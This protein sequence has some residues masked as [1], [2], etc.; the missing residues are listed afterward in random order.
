V[1]YPTCGNTVEKMDGVD[2]ENQSPKAWFNALFSLFS[3]NHQRSG[4]T[5]S[6]GLEIG[7]SHS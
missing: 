3:H 5:A 2:P 1:K 7:G 6:L 4:K